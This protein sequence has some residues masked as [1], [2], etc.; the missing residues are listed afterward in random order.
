MVK[1]TEYFY[2]NFGFVDIIDILIVSYLFFKLFVLIRGTR[3]AQMLIG[4][5]LIIIISFLADW[6]K[7]NALSWIISTIKAVWVIAFVILF[8]PELRGALA[9][10]GQSRF[11]RYFFRTQRKE[12]IDE[13]VKAVTKMSLLDIGCLIAITRENNLD[14]FI[15]TG[16]SIKSIVTSELLVTLF[17]P[18]TPLHDGAVIIKEDS[19][20]AAGCILPLTQNTN[21][22]KE[23]GTRHR[24]AIGLAEESDA[25]VIVVSEETGNISLAV[26]SEMFRNISPEVLT[27]ELKRIMY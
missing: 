19:I 5:M 8:Q 11:A 16:V 13:V 7:M 21:L 10:A 14:D 2:F 27:K 26:N 4:M 23:L 12:K 18:K 25:V 3:A 24:A 22:P 17:H 15:N 20:I 1:T 9:Q 6:L